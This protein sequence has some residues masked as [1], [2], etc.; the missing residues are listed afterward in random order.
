VK[1]TVHKKRPAE[2]FGGSFCICSQDFRA[3]ECKK[4]LSPSLILRSLATTSALQAGEDMIIA[5]SWQMAD[6]VRPVYVPA[7]V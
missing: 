6:V 2:N 4:R 5:V 7:Q 3:P 1:T